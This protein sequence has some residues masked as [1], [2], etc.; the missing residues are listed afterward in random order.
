MKTDLH[1]STK[2]CGL[3]GKAHDGFRVK[4]DAKGV[5][6]VLCGSG[7]KAKRVNVVIHDP[8]KSKNAHYPGKWTID[9]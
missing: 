3:C 6:Y 9:S 4:Q 8:T 5:Q 2:D 7:A 1:V